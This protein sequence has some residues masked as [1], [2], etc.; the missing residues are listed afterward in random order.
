VSLYLAVLDGTDPVAIEPID[1][2][3]AQLVS[4]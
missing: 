3:K 1:W 2:L 4:R